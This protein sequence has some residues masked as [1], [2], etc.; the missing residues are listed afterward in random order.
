MSPSNLPSTISTLIQPD[1]HSKHIILT[2]IS[3]PIPASDTAEHLFRV[4]A[5]AITNNEL[6]WP[7]NF[8]VAQPVPYSDTQALVPLYD[9]AGTIVIAPKD[10]PFQ[11]SAEV[12]ARTNYLKTGAGREYTIV[13]TDELALKSERLSWV[14]AASVSMSAQTAW[15][16]LFVHGGLGPEAGS[17]GKGKR[18]FVTAASGAV[19]TWVV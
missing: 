5:V 18:V 12:W 1:P 16:A 7:A 13:T 11:P 4:Y 3:L 9:V 15:Q 8:P 6:T 17:G 19:G 2:A 10:S 14:E